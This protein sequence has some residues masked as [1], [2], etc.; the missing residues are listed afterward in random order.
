M[1]PAASA[2]VPARPRPRRPRTPHV[3]GHGD[4]RLLL[5]GLLQTQPRH[6]YELIQLIAGIFHGRYQPSAGALYPTLSQLQADGLV[7]SRKDGQRRLHELTAEGRAWIEANAEAI[8]QARMRTEQSAHALVK[9]GIPAPVREA[10][11]EIKQALSRHEGHWNTAR[12]NDV[13]AILRR[14][15]TDIATMDPAP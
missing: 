3:L 8:V 14:A 9:A 5:L 10:M 4:L 13:A 7:S 15:A 2:K 12:A 1:P 11:E 6:G